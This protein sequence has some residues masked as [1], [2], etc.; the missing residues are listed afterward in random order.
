MR[1]LFFAFA[2]I[3]V[4]LVACGGDDNEA[5][6]TPQS[7]GSPTVSASTSRSPSATG[8]YNP[9]PTGSIGLTEACYGNLSPAKP[10]EVIIDTP[11]P[12]DE[13][14]SPVTVSGQI[15]AF[16]ATFLIAIKDPAN[17]DLIEPHVGHSAEGQKL[18]P[19]SE[20]VSFNVDKPTV[21][22]IW[23]YEASPRDGTPQKI[24]EIPVVLKPTNPYGVC[25]PNPD[26]ATDDQAQI[27]SPQPGDKVHTPLQV[28]GSYAAFEA[29]FNIAIK[30]AAGNDIATATAHSSEGQTQAPFSVSVPFF[31]TSEIPACLWVY[32]VSNADGISPTTVKQ[33]PITLEP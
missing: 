27:T 29:Q 5:S 16:E 23:V 26:P 8:T 1:S 21:A 7:S 20:Q 6:Q 15:D 13:I 33:V 22:C 4:L 18:S 19:F 28:T 2:T 17:N 32:D 14:T 11:G 9:T 24:H 12:S 31:V 10:S 3:T 25:G 30:G